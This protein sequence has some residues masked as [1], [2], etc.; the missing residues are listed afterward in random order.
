MEDFPAQTLAPELA[1]LWRRYLAAE[2]QGRR[3]RTMSALRGFVEALQATSEEQRHQFAEAFCR[4]VAD[5]GAALPLR[6]PLFAGIIGPFLVSA[7]QQ[8]EENAERWIV[9][10]H[11]NFSNMPPSRRLIEVPYLSPM[12]LLREALQ[13]DPDDA[14]TQDQLIQTL[15]GHFA[16]A[17]HEVPSGVLYGF[18]GATV[19]ECG[20]WEADLVL[21]RELV[22]KRQVVEKYEVA[23]RYWGF[24]FH[25]YAD[26]LTHREQYQN[27]ADYIGRHWEGGTSGQQAEE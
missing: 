27:Y 17:V 19:A 23:M 24:H 18:D 22:Q 8:G 13:R 11:P 25:G 15:A 16:Y 4:Q 14:R 12:D 7:R 20:E 26:Y 21:F 9:H 3:T 6:E 5:A 10:F 2:T 1:L